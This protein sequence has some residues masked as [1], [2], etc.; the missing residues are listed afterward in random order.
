MLVDRRYHMGWLTRILT[1]GLLVFILASHFIWPFARL[2]MIFSPIWDK[3]IDQDQMTVAEV[4]AVVDEAHANKL[5]V[6][7]HSHRPEEIR[8][9]IR[10]LGRLLAEEIEAGARVSEPAPAVV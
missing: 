7:A 10:V 4:Q 1:I 8:R 6:V 9:G 3:L 5:P 2:D